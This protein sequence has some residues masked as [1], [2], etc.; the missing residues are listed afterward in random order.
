MGPIQNLHEAISFLRRRW[1]LMAFVLLLGTVGGLILAV[2]TPRVYSASAVIQVI[3]PV[4]AV[5]EDG[6]GGG[7]TTPDVTRRVQVIEQRLMSR[8]ALLDLAQ[9]YNLFDGAPISPVEQVAQMRQ[10]FSI[11]SVA[12]AQQGFTRDGSL[13]AL[14]VSASDRNPETA[15]A[16]ANELANELV[17]QSVDARQSN[18]Q[19]ALD[20]FRSEENRLQ[21]AITGLEDD[22]ASYRSTNE[23]YMPD[24][25][26]ARRE[27]QGRLTESL[28]DLQTRISTAQNELATQDTTSRR[29][30]TQRRIAQLNEDIDQLTHQ[31]SVLNARV[32]EIQDL[33]TRAPGYQQQV[34]AME[35][36]MEQLQTQLTAAADRRREAELG[37]RIEDDQ[38]SERFELLEHALVP[39]YPVSTSRKKVAL[40]GVI[41]GLGLGG[42]LAYALEWLQPVMRTAQRMERDLNLRPVVSIPFAMP[43]REKRRRQM[44]WAFGGLVLIAAALAVGLA[45]GLL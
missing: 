31:A 1:K 35:R 33:L 26:T 3:N 44:I 28:M 12:A 39:L 37:A 19:Q 17:Q 29:A 27:E 8:E 36:Q 22:I 32:A 5:P 11:T 16:I 23:A 34:Q 42:L 13:S 21:A 43:R 40:M 18:A 10:S 30:V 25:V 7:A 4:I 2:R 9:R 20:F 15:A 45:T 14:I 41:A 6:A 24:A 38:Q